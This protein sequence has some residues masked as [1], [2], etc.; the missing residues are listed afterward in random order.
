MSEHYKL[1]VPIMNHSCD[2][3]EHRAQFLDM[4][5][6]AGVERVFLVMS[7]YLDPT[8]PQ[9]ADALALLKNNV[10]YFHENGIAEVGT[11]F[12][13]MGHGVELD[14]EEAFVGAD[15]PRAVGF[16]GGVCDDSFCIADPGYRDLIADWVRDMGKCGVDIIQL[17]DDLSLG[18]RPNGI[19]CT[20]DYHMGEFAR[21][22][23]KEWTR[24]ELYRAVFC[25]EAN[26]IRRAWFG[27]MGESFFDF[28]RALRQ[29]LDTV[30]PTTRLGFCTVST[31]FDSDGVDA[32]ELA[33]VF[34]GNTKPYLRGIGA[35]Y[36]ETVLGRCI[37]DV[38]GYQR[39]ERQWLRK[40]SDIEFYTEGD[41]YPRPRY[42]V[43][44][45]LVESYDTALRADGSTD[46]I[47]KYI[48]DYVQTPTYETGYLERHLR[49]LPLYDE[50][51]CAFNGGKIRGVQIWEQEHLL[52]DADLPETTPH[53]VGHLQTGPQSDAVRFLNRVCAASSVTDN[54]DAV[55]VMGESARH[56]PIKLLERGVVL[57]I[58]AAKLLD[59]RGVDVGIQTLTDAPVP[60]N[61]QFP[62]LDGHEA[63]LVRPLTGGSF[64]RVELSDR[65]EV[66]SHF[67]SGAERYPAAWYYENADGQRFLV[68]AFA[69]ASV[70]RNSQILTSYCRQRQFNAV[71]PRL[72]GHA[73]AAVCEGHP[74]LYMIAKDHENGARAIGLWNN[75]DDEM[76]T[77]SVVLD[78]SFAR[79]RFLGGAK[80]HIEGNTVV[81]E[82]DIAAHAFGGF[83]VEGCV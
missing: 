24:E 79:V 6:R 47:L 1:S 55:I 51:S 15:F 49:H 60:D 18:C 44:G 25:G 31:S 26:E 37:S 20:C 71:L 74:F 61:E 46:G 72:Q 4:F 9:R 50:I 5:R 81:F 27:L 39:L 17:D 57:D 14:H 29:K 19:V 64:W 10:R 30:S 48:F 28:A 35:P 59:A 77:P 2:T 83:V 75:F 32:G 58:T 38:I 70:D 34:A 63:E 69:M 23:G 22:T 45:W 78:R 56:I 16:N 76:L 52:L 66:L 43:P 36:W 40:Y 65:A 7:R 33:R 62:S 3:D 53:Q 68:Y 21:R 11:W 80:G 73:P 13:S 54:E 67:I 8:A 12:T 41:L 82:T 42:R